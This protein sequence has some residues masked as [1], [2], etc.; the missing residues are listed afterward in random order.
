MYDD[1]ILELDFF[2]NIKPAFNELRIDTILDSLTKVVLRKFI[3]D[4]ALYLINQKTPFSFLIIDIDN[5]KRINDNYGHQVGDEVLVMFAKKLATVVGNDGLVGRY[6][7]DEFIVI[8]PHKN[9]YDDVHDYISQKFFGP[10]APMR[11]RY[12]INLLHTFM[13]GTIGSA[14]YPNDAVEFNDL[15][16]KADKALYRGKTK[17]RNCY[18]VYVD[19]KHKDI[20]VNQGHKKHLNEIFFDVDRLFDS[21]VDINDIVYKL[22]HYLVDELKLTTFEYF[23]D[24]SNFTEVPRL[25]NN[26]GIFASSD[27]DELTKY[28]SLYGYISNNRVLSVLIHK[29]VVRNKFYGYLVFT[30]GK[31]HRIWQDEDIALIQYIAKLLVLM[32]KDN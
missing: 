1:D 31:I 11:S 6:G 21:T 4:Y 17:G 19:A 16:A 13:T 12:R 23:L 3:L 29:V 30:E 18:I 20:D 10:G 14:S 25:L 7:G 5:F 8:L 27:N 22:N 24:D 15:F 2:Q 26:K 28:P 9:N 32:I